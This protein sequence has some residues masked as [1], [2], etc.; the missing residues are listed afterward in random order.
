MHATVEASVSD[1]QGHGQQHPDQRDLDHPFSQV[2]RDDQRNADEQ[3]GG[4]P[5]VAR[6][7][8]R[9]HWRLVE[10]PHGRP[11]PIDDEGGQQEHQ[12]LNADREREEHGFPPAV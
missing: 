1:Q 5:G 9:R 3:G 11:H 4:S 10:R 7:E 2:P 6:R 12:R 8:A